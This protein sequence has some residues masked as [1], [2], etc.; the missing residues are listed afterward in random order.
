MVV[1]DRDVER[2]PARSGRNQVLQIADVLL[3]RR[4]ARSA[5]DRGGALGRDGAVGVPR[6][7]GVTPP[8]WARC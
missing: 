5:A 4:N 6:T 7:P 3:D 1:F 2:I 8:T